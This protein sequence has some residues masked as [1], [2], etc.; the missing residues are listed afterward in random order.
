MALE[1]VPDVDLSGT[2]WPEFPNSEVVNAS[3]YTARGRV[4]GY[5]DRDAA[6]I[7]RV[8]AESH[9]VEPEQIVLG[10]GAAELLQAAAFARWLTPDLDSPFLG[11]AGRSR[12]LRALLRGYW[13][14]V[15]ALLR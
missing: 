6:R 1:E 12:L 11:R 5:P 3:I 15:L 8:L 9:G 7:R 2:E 13:R 10:N 4:N 14:L